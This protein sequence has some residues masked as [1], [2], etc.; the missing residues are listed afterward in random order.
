MNVSSILINLNTTGKYFRM[1]VS[2]K[3]IE[4]YYIIKVARN[5]KVHGKR[6]SSF[7]K[8]VYKVNQKTMHKKF[9]SQSSNVCQN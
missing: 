6:S 7:N 5:I 8:G 2:V 3:V 9:L 4:N 1:K